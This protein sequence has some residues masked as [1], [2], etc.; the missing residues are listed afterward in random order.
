MLIQFYSEYLTRKNTLES[1][2]TK[3]REGRSVSVQVPR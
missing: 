2:H 1:K 3:G